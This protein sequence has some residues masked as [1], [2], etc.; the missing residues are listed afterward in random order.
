MKA[1]RAS[2]RMSKEGNG[3][4]ERRDTGPAWGT[5]GAGKVSSGPSPLHKLGYLLHFSLFSCRVCDRTLRPFPVGGPFPCQQPYSFNPAR[6]STAQL[7][8]EMPS[9]REGDRYFW[10]CAI[11][12]ATSFTSLPGSEETGIKCPSISRLSRLIHKAAHSNVHHHSQRQ[13]HKQH[14]RPAVTH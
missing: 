2:P 9:L 10:G 8:G 13:E 14:R 7:A 11:G 1:G 4:I 6:P 3:R 5:A 12:A